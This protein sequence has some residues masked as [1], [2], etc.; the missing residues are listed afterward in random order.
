MYEAINRGF[1]I[2]NGKFLTWIN[3]DDVYFKNNLLKAV[4]FMSKKI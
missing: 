4:N 2:A 1:N 3:S